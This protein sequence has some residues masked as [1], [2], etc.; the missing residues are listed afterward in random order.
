VLAGA[1]KGVQSGINVAP[2][3]DVVLVLLILF[4]VITPMLQRGMPVQLP[5]ARTLSELMRGGDPIVISIT[6]DGRT[7]LDRREVRLAQLAGAL[8][9]AAAARPSAVVVLKG[10][11]S[12][13]YKTVRAVILEAAR[14]RLPGLSLAATELPAGANGEVR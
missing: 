14:A 10:D 9:A 12:V 2:L 1:R 5:A 6:A 8:A 3:V 13:D 7:W 11:R 4:M